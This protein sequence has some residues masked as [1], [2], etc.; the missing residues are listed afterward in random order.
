MARKYGKRKYKRRNRNKITVPKA[1]VSYDGPKNFKIRLH[2]TLTTDA[3]GKCGFRINVNQ[4]N[5]FFQ[6]N[7]Q[8]AEGLPAYTP[9]ADLFDQY[10]VKA[11]KVKYL[12]RYSHTV[13][14]VIDPTNP[15]EPKTLGSSPAFAI[16]QDIDNVG[17][18][19][20]DSLV[21]RDRVKMRSPLRSWSY[22]AKV[23]RTIQTNERL[24]ERGGWKNMQAAGTNTAG[25]IMCAQS[26][27]LYLDDGT[28]ATG[29]S[30]GEVIVTCYLQCKGSQ[31]K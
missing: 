2:S 3:F 23:P 9:L 5:G 29:I 21:S 28:E 7:S 20:Y 26:D 10:R 8:S 13:Q 30:M 27:P 1:M 14:N 25:V 15:T 16:A 31:V 12:A 4:L 22:Y 6:P 19:T 17:D 24:V 11:V 18:I